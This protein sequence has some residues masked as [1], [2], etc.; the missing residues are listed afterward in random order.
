MQDG[1]FKSFAS[2]NNS[3][4]CP[5]VMAALA[6]ANKGHAVGYGDDPWTERALAR[7]KEE[8]GP[9]SE[10]FFVFNGT[11]SNILGLS[12][13]AGHGQAVLSSDCAHVAVDEAGAA[14]AVIG[15]KVL[16]L[17][18]KEGKILPEA[19]EEALGVLGSIHQS[20]PSCLSLTQPTELGTLYKPEE[21]RALV[22]IARSAGLKVHMDGARLA[23]AA[24]AL[25]L[26][27]RAATL[28][29][30]VDLLS[31][32]GMKNGVAFGEALVVFDPSLA[33]R[34]PFLRK[35]MLQLDSKMRFISAQYEAYLSGG[36]WKRN[37]DAS[38]GAARSLALALEGLPRLEIAH[39]VEANAVF[40]RIPAVAA[41]KLREDYFFY[42]WEEG[43][44]RWMTSFDT[45][46]ADIARFVAALSVAL[47]DALH[48][49]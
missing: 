18:T 12:L 47:G 33:R 19:L 40:A 13:A 30:G 1:I 46:A 37:A 42:D 45:E 17:D 43:M 27:L 48:G 21:I 16:A 25:G 24:A 41:A 38:N 15:A 31:F 35:T 9:E 3:G 39:P 20:Q 23:N 36:L 22:R 4:A 29:L 26:G 7:F 49:A 5:E 6:A 8:F 11:G 14:E 34:A 28:D 44:V 32:G 10:T 2:D